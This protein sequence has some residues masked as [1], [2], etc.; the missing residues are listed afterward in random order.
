[1]RI[2]LL[3]GSFDPPHRGHLE[4]ARFCVQN[5]Q[6]L[7]IIPAAHAPLKKHS[8]I[9]SDEHRIHML[10]LLLSPL[11][12]WEIDT[13]ELLQNPPN[14][15]I[16]TLTEMRRRFRD[17]QFTIAIGQDQLVQFRQWKN[18]AV[19]VKWADLLCFRRSGELPAYDISDLPLTWVED[20]DYAIS[21]MQLR[22]MLVRKDPAVSQWIPQSVLEYI[23]DHALYKNNQVQG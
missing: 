22:A 18:W 13:W 6:R 23:N 15:T 20:F 4:M 7:L 8:P 1:M 10:E 2:T 9:V 17:A 21:S 5:S 12:G 14:F 16:D 19:I 11:D 3:G